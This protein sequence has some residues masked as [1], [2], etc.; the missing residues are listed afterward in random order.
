MKITQKKSQAPIEFMILVGTLFFLLFLFGLNQFA[1]AK[2]AYAEKESGLVYDLALKLQEEIRMASLV[3]NGYSR[4][5]T[6]PP[7]LENFDYEIIMDN[8]FLTIKSNTALYTVKGPNITGSIN[9]GSNYIRKEGGAVY[10][11]Q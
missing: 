1:D 9:K 11:N 5:F 6:I 2:R 7:K 4:N 3:E 8:K 10:F